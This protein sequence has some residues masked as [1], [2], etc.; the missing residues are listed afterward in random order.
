MFLILAMLWVI[1]FQLNHII[2]VIHNQT[3]IQQ[4]EKQKE[5]NFNE[6]NK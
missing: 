2:G 3:Q 6:N 1:S 4:Q 5:I